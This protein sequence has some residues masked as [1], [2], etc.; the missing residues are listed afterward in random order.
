MFGG[1]SGGWAGGLVGGLGMGVGIVFG[2]GG[3]VYDDEALFGEVG[4]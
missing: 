4:A 3:E 1:F 2:G